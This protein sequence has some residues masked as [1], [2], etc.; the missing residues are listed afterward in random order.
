MMSSLLQWF[1]SRMHFNWR[2]TYIQH[3][4]IPVISHICTFVT[5]I[6]YLCKRLNRCRNRYAVS[7]NNTNIYLLYVVRIAQNA[8]STVT[9]GTRPLLS[10][11][12]K[13]FNMIG[14][15]YLLREIIPDFCSLTSE[16]IYSKTRC[17]YKWLFKLWPP[18]LDHM[19][20]LDMQTYFFRKMGLMFFTHLNISITMAFICDT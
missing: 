19:V 20:D 13:F 17:A 10:E 5:L 11:L 16:R 7:V 6:P 2:K 9:F 8:I 1:K 18:L 15:L 12:F 14:I 4:I 3:T